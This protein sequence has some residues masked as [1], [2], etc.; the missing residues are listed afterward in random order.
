MD[1]I[2]R[3]LDSGQNLTP[4]EAERAMS[5]IMG[6][7]ASNQEIKSFL[8]GLKEKGETIDEIAAFTRVLMRFAAKVECTPEIA[9]RLVDTCGSGGDVLDTFN[10]STTAAFVVAGAGVPVAKHGNRSVS[11]KSGSVDVLE[12]LGVNINLNAESVRR[13]IEEAGIG[14]MYA[15]A[16]HTAMKNV[17]QARRELATR[18]VFNILG[19][20]ISPAGVKH[21][22]YGIFDHALTEKLAGVLKRM[23]SVHALVVHGMDGLDEL[24]TIGKTKV[25][26]L[27]NGVVTSY[28]IEPEDYGLRRTEPEQLLGGGPKENAEIL[29]AI[30]EGEHGPKR[31]IVVLNA[32]AAIYAADAARTLKAGIE[33]ANDSIDSDRAMDRLQKLIEVSNG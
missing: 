32:G 15:P 14:F 1:E 19:P 22:L 3:K 2:L 10:I 31:D 33:M 28:Y 16:F 7:R 29:M 5:A 4:E 26:E 24:S 6:G 9:G 13:C 30:L 21:Q 25:S 12:Q 20:L 17:A 23:G 27:R 8:L 18:T 11:S